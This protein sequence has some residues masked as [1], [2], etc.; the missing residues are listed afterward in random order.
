[1]LGRSKGENAR[2]MLTLSAE[3]KWSEQHLLMV[4]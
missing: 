3:G 2:F 1:V 4:S